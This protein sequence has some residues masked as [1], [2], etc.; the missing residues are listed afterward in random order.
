[1]ANID[2]SWLEKDNL[3]QDDYGTRMIY[4]GVEGG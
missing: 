4:K 1:M 3:W 2:S